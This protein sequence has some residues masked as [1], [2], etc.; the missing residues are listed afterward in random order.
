MSIGNGS[1][2]PTLVEALERAN[3]GDD[4]TILK[5]IIEC[6]ADP[7]DFLAAP[8]KLQTV[9]DFLNARQAYDAWSCRSGSAR[10]AGRQA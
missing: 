10:R 1:R 4:Q 7:R 6:A 9:I 2:L 5:N 3:R 8:D